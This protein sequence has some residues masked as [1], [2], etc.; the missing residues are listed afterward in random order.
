MLLAKAAKIEHPGVAFCGEGVG[1]FCAEGKTGAA[2]RGELFCNYLTKT[3]EVDFPCARPLSIFHR[4]EVARKFQFNC[5][6]HFAACV[7]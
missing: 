5:V 6:E 2:I 3:K 4:K 7:Q 1:P